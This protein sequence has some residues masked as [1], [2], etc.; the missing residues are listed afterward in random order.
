MFFNFWYFL[1]SGEMGCDWWDSDDV[2]SGLV[3]D[4]TRPLRLDKS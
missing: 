3:V 1:F 2:A 4:E